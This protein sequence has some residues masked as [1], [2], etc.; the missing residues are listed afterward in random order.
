MTENNTR[1]GEKRCQSI[2][3]QKDS[4]KGQS[5]G[6]SPVKPNWSGKTTVLSTFLESLLNFLSNAPKKNTTIFSTVRE[7]AVSKFQLPERIVVD[8]M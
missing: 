5:T 2:N 7:N 8:H 6:K 1:R 3:C 4:L